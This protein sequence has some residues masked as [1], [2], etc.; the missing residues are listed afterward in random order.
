MAKTE[1]KV[2]P[3]NWND[4]FEKSGEPPFELLSEE[5]EAKKKEEEDLNTKYLRL[6]ADFQNYR[7]RVESEK[8]EIYAFANEKFALDLLDVVDNFERALL[9]A[10]ECQ[11]RQFA[12]GMELIFK[13]L[14]DM[15]AKN[16]VREIDSLGEPFD[17]N[18]HHAVMMEEADEAESGKVTK[19]LKKGYTLNE[20]VI[21]PA[22]VAVAQ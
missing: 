1:S 2:F 19:V 14:L 17:P 8:N 13:Q 9:H 4:W 3:Q 5:Q 18:M 20:R 15:L 7:R 16:N 11:D 6:A 22:M 10:Q 21:R 12:E